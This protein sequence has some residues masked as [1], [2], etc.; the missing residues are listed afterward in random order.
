MENRDFEKQIQF[1]IEADKMKSI[2]R[3]TLL[4]DKSRCENDAEHSWHLALMAMTLFEYAYSPEVDMLRVLKM[5]LVHDLVEVYAGDTFAYDEKGYEDKQQREN[6]AADKLFGILPEEQGREY[7]ALWEEFDAMKTAD[8]LYASAVDRLQPLLSNYMTQGHTWKD[9]S[10]TSDRV[11]KR[12]ELIKT[13][14]PAAWPLVEKIV[15][16]SIANGWLK[17]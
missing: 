15:S 1:L 6:D 10:V 17:P 13:A 16:E 7:R 12:M 3:R 5:A 9:G 2:Y 8:A 14:I 11:L 4:M